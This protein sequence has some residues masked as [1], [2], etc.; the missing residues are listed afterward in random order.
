MFLLD[1][2][3]IVTLSYH[4]YVMCFILFFHQYTVYLFCCV[5]WTDEQVKRHRQTHYA[6]DL[7][8][9]CTRF[10]RATERALALRGLCRETRSCRLRLASSS[11]LFR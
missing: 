8:D 4:L 2:Q 7:H 6:V 1:L 10:Q 5:P 3:G 9:I 11:G